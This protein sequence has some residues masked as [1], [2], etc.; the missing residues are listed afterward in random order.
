MPRVPHLGLLPLYLAFYDETLP[1][2]RAEMAAFLAQVEDTLINVGL[3]LS[4]AQIYCTSDEIAVAVQQFERASVDLLV[5]VHLT[6]APSLETVDALASTALPLLLLDT[7]PDAAFGQD[8]DPQRLLYNH[9]IHGV[10]DLATMLRRKK[11]TYQ[12]VAGHLS[13]PR[14]LSRTRAI[15]QAAVAVHAFNGAHVLRIGPPFAGMGDFQV[16]PAVLQAQFGI[17]V[18]AITPLAL[19]PMVEAV[20]ETQLIDELALDAERY[21]VEASPEVHRRSVRLGLGLRDYLMQ[22]GYHAFSMNFSAFD[23]PDAPLCTVPFLE[24]SNAMARGIG[25]AGEGDVLT[26]AFVGALQAGFGQTTFTEMFCPDWAGD[27][28]FLSHM[29]EMNPDVAAATPVLYEKDYPFSPASNPACLA[30]APRTGPATLANLAPGPDDTFRLIVAPV[31]VL[32]DGTHPDLRH[33]VRGWIRPAMPVAR[34]LERYS[35]RGGTHHCAL[36]LGE[37]CDE[38]SVFA[39]LLDIECCRIPE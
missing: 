34:F 20:T 24:C 18:D 36:V 19:I 13:D 30:L 33:W 15:A 17:T 10:Q 38:L 11:K 23:S 1:E 16:E 2:L 31:E 35:E 4:T 29:G 37:R 8:V 7:T 22:G 32:E 12:V 6:Y 3:Q 26:A 9:G 14:V 28:I 39:K 27:A 5:T 25:Y 21:I